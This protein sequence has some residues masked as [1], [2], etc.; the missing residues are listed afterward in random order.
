M[1]RIADILGQKYPQYNTV[2]S[3]CYVS[4]ALYQMCCENVDHLVVFDNDKFIGIITDQDIAS[5]VLYETRPLNKIAVKDFVNTTLPVVTSSDNL[6]QC[7]QLMERYHAKHVAVFDNDNLVFKGVLSI[8][9]L[10][11]KG[12]AKPNLNFEETESVK[13]GYPWTY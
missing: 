13:H 4:D 11:I 8:Q 2:S 12:Y 9:D 5:K 1:E 6:A 10:L 7:I 3:D